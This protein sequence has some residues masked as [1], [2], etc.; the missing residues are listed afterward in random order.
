MTHTT[1]HTHHDHTHGHKHHH[2]ESSA[3][4]LEHI[5]KA[6]QH[7]LEHLAKGTDTDRKIAQDIIEHL[8]SSAE[9]LEAHAE[10]LA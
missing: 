4:Q 3:H 8:I 1:A 6:G 2:H 10:H 7:A 5:V 9:A